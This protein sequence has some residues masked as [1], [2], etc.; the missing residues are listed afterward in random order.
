MRLWYE[1]LIP[2]LP[3]MNN[4]VKKCL[5]DENDYKPCELQ[6]IDC[7]NCDYFG[8]EDEKE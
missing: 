7:E 1:S 6:A 4:Q 5:W 2:K 8:M 3:R